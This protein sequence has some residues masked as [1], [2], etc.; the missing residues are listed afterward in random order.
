MSKKIEEIGARV[1]VTIGIIAMVVAFFWG[2]T[3]VA[4]HEKTV[5]LHSDTGDY[6]CMV[7]PLSDGPTNCKPIEG[8][9]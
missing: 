8:M 1:A 7:W 5:I 2:I 3:Y 4:I 6:A 9:K